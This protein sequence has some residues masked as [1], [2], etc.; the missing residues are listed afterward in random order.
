MWKELTI[1]N[2]TFKPSQMN[3]I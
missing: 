3:K 1:E 2:I